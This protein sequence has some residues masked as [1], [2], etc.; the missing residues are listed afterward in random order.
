MLPIEPYS[1]YIFSTNILH[2][3]SRVGGWIVCDLEERLKDVPDDVLKVAD[4]R[5]SR[6]LKQDS[7][8]SGYFM[9]LNLQVSGY[10]VL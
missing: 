10:L 8:I 1:V 4:P 3:Q 7:T 5:I 2:V 6:A 9:R